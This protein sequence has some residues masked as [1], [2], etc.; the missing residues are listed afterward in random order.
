M[1]RNQVLDPM[2]KWPTRLVLLIS[3]MACVL[4]FAGAWLRPVWHD[5]LYTLALARLPVNELL[6]ALVVDSSMVP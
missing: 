6:S 4:A 1:N 3:S 2:A 5:E